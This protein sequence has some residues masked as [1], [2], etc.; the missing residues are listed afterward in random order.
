MTVILDELIELDEKG[1]YNFYKRMPE[2]VFNHQK[3]FKM[4][5]TK[6]KEG[7]YYKITDNKNMD[8]IILMLKQKFDS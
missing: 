6:Y 8:Y 1:E 4:N 7:Y 2:T 3:L 5:K